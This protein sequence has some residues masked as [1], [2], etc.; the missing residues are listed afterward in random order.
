[1]GRSGIVLS[2]VKAR[3]GRASYRLPMKPELLASAYFL[4]RLHG[5]NFAAALLEEH[6]MA[7]SHALRLLADRPLDLLPNQGDCMQY[8][9]QLVNFYYRK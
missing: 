3:P 2:F 7:R 6:G 9:N 8:P 1:L 4:Q 5:A